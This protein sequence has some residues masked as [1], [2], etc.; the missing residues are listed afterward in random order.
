MKRI[1]QSCCS[2]ILAALA[3]LVAAQLVGGMWWPSGGGVTLMG[4]GLITAGCLARWLA[5]HRRLPVSVFASGF[6]AMMACFFAAA[7]AEQLPP[8]SFEWMLKGGLFGA[9]VGL[10]I[11]LVLSPLGLLEKSSVTESPMIE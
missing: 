3:G 10:P 2:S 5:V 4:I 11:T 1:L 6:G 9:C 8:G 7:T